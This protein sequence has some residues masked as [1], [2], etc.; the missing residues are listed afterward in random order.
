MLLSSGI[1]LISQNLVNRLSSF[2]SS[3]GMNLTLRQSVFKSLLVTRLFSF[4]IG[5]DRS[6]PNLLSIAI[7]TSFAIRNQLT[8]IVIS[9]DDIYVKIL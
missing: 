8:V 7:K 2:D 1:M 4:G 6:H 9:N 5:P 3:T